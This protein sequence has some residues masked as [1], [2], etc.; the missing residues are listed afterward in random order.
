MHFY[1]FIV[2][3][4]H[5]VRS[6]GSLIGRLQYFGEYDQCKDVKIIVNMNGKNQTWKGQYTFIYIFSLQFSGSFAWCATPSCYE[7]MKKAIRC[8]L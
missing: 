3:D 4:S 5:G 1:F 7:F 2:E 6:S 8:I